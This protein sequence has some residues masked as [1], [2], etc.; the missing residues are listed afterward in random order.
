MTSGTTDRQLNLVRGVLRDV[1]YDGRA[2]VRNYDF[3]VPDHANSLAHV[4][5]AAFSDPVRHDLRTS[6]IAAQRVSNGSDIEDSL[7]K[8][9]YLAVPWALVLEPD[10]VGLWPVGRMGHER[11]VRHIP[12]DGLRAFF[13]DHRAEFR[14]ATLVAAKTSAHQLSFFELDRSLLDFAFESTQEILVDRFEAA[15]RAAKSALGEETDR[16]PGNVQELVL[17]LLAAAILDDKYCLGDARSNSA[18][19]LMRRSTRRYGRYFRRFPQ[20]STWH[21]VADIT[22]ESLRRNVTFRS[23]TNE[24]LGYFYENALVDKTLRQELGIHYTPQSIA[25]RILA[26]MPIEDIP[27]SE[28]SVFD[29]SCGSGNLLIAAYERMSKLLPSNWDRTQKHN[30]LVKRIH[31]VDLDPFA[32]QVAR[33]SLL[34]VD[35]FEGDAWDLRTHDFIAANPGNWAQRPT[36]LVGN[37]PF[38]ELRSSGG[39][40]SQRANLFLNKYLDVLEPGGLIGMVLPETFLENS[41]CRDARMRLLE[42]CT[43]L[44]LW[45]LPEGVF[46]ASNAATTVVIAR[47]RPPMHISR[48][49]PVRVERV[50]SPAQE[51]RGFLNGARPRFSYVLTSARDWTVD[52]DAPMSTSPLD[53]CVWRALKSVR[54]LGQVAHVRNGIIPGKR[55]RSDHFALESSGPEWKPWI[56][57]SAEFEPYALKPKQA[58]FVRYPGDLHRPRTDLEA[59][60]VAP[61]SKVLVNSGRAPGNPWRLFAA[62]DDVGYFPSQG[63]HCI[64]PKDDSVSLEEFT[65]FLNSSVASAWI[66]SR[67]R[68]RWI[69]EDTLRDMPFPVMTNAKRESLQQHAAEVA[70]LKKRMLESPSTGSA[71]VAA[72]RDHML[73]IDVLVCDAMG[74]SDEGRAMLSKLFTGYRRPGL[75]WRSTPRT[76]NERPSTSDVRKW[77]VTG[78]VIDVVAETNTVT[79][80]I[81]GFN[82]N[83]PFRTQIPEDLPGWALRPEVAFE[84]EVP[85]IRQDPEH[86]PVDGLTNFRPMDFSYAGTEDL[87]DLLANPERLNDLYGC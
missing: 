70:N 56:G 81:R 69:G 18:E 49:D 21:K 26:R 83:E 9:T 30:H 19:D 68:R 74:I 15:V 5:L 6:C 48:S 39:Q 40:R 31:G 38:R 41:S 57:G 78:Q 73:A 64:I 20:D 76:S 4:D 22:F 44:E 82:E 7:G 47:K 23:F 60:F 35:L 53:R 32:A 28:R 25:K 84:A 27:P 2:I 43:L 85:W 46:P 24:M 79:L 77:T 72:I 10:R 42:E 52:P 54:T 61:N 3:A 66:D 12:Y 50:G 34:F 63:I 11:P 71:Q 29:G 80:W 36:I 51:K 37:P 1:G 33:L 87:V 45:Q 8:L 17:Q 58:R 67:N 13:D 65:A 62:I 86:I 55:Q 75:E 16:L 59:I 14:P